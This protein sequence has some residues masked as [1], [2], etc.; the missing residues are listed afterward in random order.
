M[1]KERDEGQAGLSLHCLELD[2]LEQLWEGPHLMSLYL[3]GSPLLT[4]TGICLS[5]GMMN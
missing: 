2:T 1:K 4:L 3:L 5:S